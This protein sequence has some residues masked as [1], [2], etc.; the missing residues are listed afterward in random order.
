MIANLFVKDID[1][2]SEKFMKKQIKKASKKGKKVESMD[3]D[4]VAP[5]V[6]AVVEEVV[7]KKV[8]D[9][10]AADAPSSTANRVLENK[11]TIF[12]GNV[13]LSMTKNCEP[14]KELFA[15][16]GEIHSLRFRSIPRSRLLKRAD[17][18]K[19]KQFS[20]KRKTCNAYIIYTEIESAEKALQLN[21]HE[22]MGHMLRVDKA[23]LRKNDSGVFVGN[24][25]PTVE[26][27]DLHQ[28]FKDCGEIDY[29]RVVRDRQMNLGK[30]IAY[31]VF[32][33]SSSIRLALRLNNSTLHDRKLR[34]KKIEKQPKLKS[35][36][37]TGK[38]VAKRLK[39]LKAPKINK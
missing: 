4:A 7:E 16:Y 23:L 2:K 8:V 32:K 34:I 24:L 33:E 30:G 37:V 17:A 27:M 19:H 14:L 31:V 36:E 13:D 38:D 39:K 22:F 20:D 25:T 18:V 5:D 6:P 29:I 10:V 3:V 21:G 12:V 15:Q 1:A 28:H 11:K 35:R 9:E 26:E